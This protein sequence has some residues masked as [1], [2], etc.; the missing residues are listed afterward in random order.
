MLTA[1]QIRELLQMR[2]HPIEGG[3][4]AETYRACGPVDPGQSLLRCG[5]P[6]GPRDLHG[7]LLFADAGYLFGDAPR[8]RRRNVPF[9]SG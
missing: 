2:P 1:K 6:G 4:F 5:Y 7:D 3:Y 8:A 9:L